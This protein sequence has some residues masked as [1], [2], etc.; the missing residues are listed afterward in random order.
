MWLLQRIDPFPLFSTCR[1]VA[2]VG[3]GGKTT[4][5]EYLATK[6]LQGGR[7]AVVT[8]TTKIRAEK[9]YALFHDLAQKR[10]S[11]RVDQNGLM[12]VGRS[13]SEDKL[14]SLSFAEVAALE[15][16]FDFIVI[17]ADGAKG[18]PLKYPS[19]REPVIP[20]FSDHTVVVAGLDS[21]GDRVDN[22]IF[23]WELLRDAAGVPG[24]ALIDPELFE[25]L[26]GARAM[27]K[28][29]EPARCTILLNKWEACR[30][31]E[32]VVPLAK[33]LI[34]KTGAAR[35]VISS[36]FLNIFYSVSQG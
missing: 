5:G 7:R 10:G 1:F 20:P 27:M 28:G 17:E 26:F 8:T 22:R 4:F 13:I 9:P 23:R 33:R 18:R 19:A 15:K 34:K 35:V 12:R 3:G 24:D 32:Q 21:L 25:G 6:A 29:V 14:T 11:P 36:L 2:T 16:M 31:R 30:H